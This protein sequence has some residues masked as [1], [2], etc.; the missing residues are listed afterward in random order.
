MSSRRQSRCSDN[1]GWLNNLV[2]RV[3]AVTDELNKVMEKCSREQHDSLQTLEPTLL[4]EAFQKGEK[5]SAEFVD[6]VNTPLEKTAK[7]SRT[8][9]TPRRRASANRAS[10]T[11]QPGA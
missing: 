6:W 1:R 2:K 9:T 10:A 3:D 7:Q 11:V 5:K 4:L 8:K